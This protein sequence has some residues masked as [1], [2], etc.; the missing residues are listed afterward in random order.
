MAFRDNFA[1]CVARLL[2][3]GVLYLVPDFAHCIQKL[4]VELNPKLGKPVL[5]SLHIDSVFLVGNDCYTSVA[6]P[7]RDK[8]LIQQNAVV[9]RKPP[10]LLL[11]KQETASVDVS[12]GG[13]QAAAVVAVE[14]FHPVLDGLDSV[15]E[16]GHVRRLCPRVQN[17]FR[18]ACPQEATKSCGSG[19]SL[20]PSVSRPS[21]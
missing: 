20:S 14:I 19:N 12:D 21:T 7:L 13:C 6:R 10:E 9:R 1:G 8:I 15:I 18:S 2:Q 3:M 16:E 4:P 5:D 11:A 17:H